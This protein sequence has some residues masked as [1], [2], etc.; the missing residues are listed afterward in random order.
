MKKLFWMIQLLLVP[1]LIF[2]C[3]GE[4]KTVETRWVKISG[5]SFIPGQP[6]VDQDLQTLI[7]YA[8][9]ENT[10]VGFT[11]R[12]YVDGKMVKEGKGNL[13]EKEK[14]IAGAEVYV[15]IRAS[16]G[17]NQ[18]DWLS[19]PKSQVAESG[20]KITRVTIE[21]ENPDPDQT[22]TVRVECEQCEGIKMYY[23]WL[24]NQRILEDKTEQEL[25][26]SD[27][28][29]KP[30]DRVDVEVSPEPQYP[31]NWYQSL[32]IRVNNRSPEFNEQGKIWI[33][34]K[35]LYFK[36]SAQDPD[37][38]PV[39]YQLIQGP[40]GARLDAA[41]GLVK[42]TVPEDFQGEVSFKVQARD[43]RAGVN[44]LEQSLQIQQ[45]EKPAETPAE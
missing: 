40:S 42:W 13:L 14:L 34:G 30:Y 45:Q 12:W 39:S 23:R 33:E 20:I 6:V 21:P 32:P 17:V 9:P 36:F 10:K 15:E 35:T 26:G 28:G 25:N 2:G 11:Y 31:K 37:G 8:T 41:A 27:A 24:V 1:A 19:S 22:L 5:I 3:K 18:T 4:K 38:D 7:D 43:T 29:L 16:D 44:V